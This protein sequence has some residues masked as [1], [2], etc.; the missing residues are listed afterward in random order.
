MLAI[1]PARVFRRG[2]V[3]ALSAALAGCGG[4]ASA[5]EARSAA[6]SSSA[7]ASAGA[8]P[9]E[10][11]LGDLRQL[12]FGGENAE[13]Y[14][15]N[16]GS[17]LILQSRP[18]SSGCDRI[19]RMRVAELLPGP[20]A[21]LPSIGRTADLV[22]VSSGKGATTCSF[23]LPGDH[24]V[25]Y[26]S[27]HLGGDECPPRPDHSQGYVWA[28][29]DHYDIFRAKAD[30]SSPVRLTNTPGYDAE[31][32]VCAKDGSIVFT[33]VRDG[34]IDLYRMDADGKN[35][36][37]L[38]SGVGYDGGAFFNA[39]CSKIVWRA[40]RPKPGKELDDYK[41]LLAEG[42]VRPTKLELYVA[43]A[44]GSDP[45]QVTYLDAASFAPFWHP[46]QQR[47]VFASNY[48]DP[49]GREFD[50]YAVDVQGTRLER[51]TTARGFDG[52]PMFSPDG[53]YL[54]FSSN[55]AT[56][57]GAHDTNVF[58]ARWVDAEPRPLEASAPGVEGTEPSFMDWPADRVLADVRW[59]ADPA[60]EGRG[61][62]TAG[63][64]DAGAYLE[65]RYASLGLAPAGD[66]SGYRQPFQVTTGVTI[67]SATALKLGGAPIATDAM[68][69][70][71]YSSTGEVKADVVLAGYG[72]RAEELGVDDYKKVDVKGKIALV[73]RFVPENGKFDDRDTQ[74]RYGDI[75]YKAWTAKEN[76]AKG[77]IV[78]DAPERPKDAPKDWKAP[79]EGALPTAN[80]VGYADAGIPIVVVKRAAAAP[81]L[82]KLTRKQPIR[83][84][85][86]VALTPSKREA[87]NVV[88]RLAGGA[89]PDRR[90]PGVVVVGAHYDHLG[91]GGQDSLSPDKHEPHV[92]ADDN[93]SGTAAL[94]EVARA[95][96]LRKSDLR[97]D[98]VF[99]SFSGEEMG[100][101]G[102]T[103]FTRAPPAGLKVDDVV[104]M[105]NMDMVGRLRENRVAVL[106]SDSA[107]EW[108]GLVEAACEKSRVDCAPSGD[109]FGPSDQTPF[110]AAGVPVVHFFTGS[111]SDYHKPSDTADKINAAGAAQIARVVADLA[112][113]VADRDAKLTR[114]QMPAP[115][116]RG[117]VRSFHASLG[118]IP[119]YGGPPE[120]KKG[121]LLAGVRPGGPAEKGGLRRGDILVRLGTHALG[122][123][124][125]LMYALNASK[126]GETVTAV[127]LRD[128]KEVK[129]EVT[130]QE[131]S[132][133]K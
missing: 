2:P 60:R 78:V 64:A 24:D 110:Y 66:G 89:S 86:R 50:I 105:I 91:M 27:T 69:P 42:L 11:H 18:T 21:P 119:D 29:Y 61:V 22:P 120:G 30:G 101:L 93:A 72:V 65:K 34:D 73:R 15:S 56:A 63:L 124:E 25:I 116:P 47:I 117:D 51:I 92:G 67:E 132:A 54:A 57:P 6:R 112:V 39:D 16:D 95:L 68:V 115:P 45:M 36:K 129:L 79:D 131:S 104:A 9:G 71:G 88:A 14:W 12:T 8:E 75:R 118:T 106:G 41:R 82:E 80:D 81:A 40:S 107:T 17:E 111:H 59:L 74:R 19:Y 83:A 62:E 13:A 130:F 99:A 44:D 108:K 76:G 4:A 35:V 113:S 122:D 109:G 126:P 55:R 97:R 96:S 52:F 53:K 77:L 58:V 23:F 133:R 114:K 33:S 43:N 10:V 100:V 94:L 3:F 128:G 121:V 37:R 46:S 70:M 103:H 1:P 98:I 48:G 90:L 123:V 85:L 125:D 31:G 28:L 87:F 127:V 49:Q 5:P 38:T 7:R 26:A 20:G 84:E 32:T 102:S